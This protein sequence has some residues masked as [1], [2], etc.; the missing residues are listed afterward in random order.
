MLVYRTYKYFR[1]FFL[2]K[3]LQIITL[4]SN[5]TFNSIFLFYKFL[6]GRERRNTVIS[7][8]VP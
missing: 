1:C 4:Y 8:T 7:A 6:K 2:L 3:H 5:E